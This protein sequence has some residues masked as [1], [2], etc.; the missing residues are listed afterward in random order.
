MYDSRLCRFLSVDPLAPKYPELTTY[1]FASNT[2]IMA[3][4]LDG[5]ESEVKTVA[6]SGT[7]SGQTYRETGSA[8]YF[9]APLN[10]SSRISIVSQETGNE[11]WHQDEAV[12]TAK[13]DAPPTLY[14]S[15]TLAGSLANF[16]ITFKEGVGFALGIYSYHRWEIFNQQEHDAFYKSAKNIAA[17]ELA[18]CK[19]SAVYGVGCLTGGTSA[20]VLKSPAL[21]SAIYNGVF[22]FGYQ[23]VTN[24]F[25]VKQVNFV[26]VLSSS[27]TLTKIP[28]LNGFIQAGIGEGFKATYDGGYDGIGGTRPVLTVFKDIMVGGLGNSIGDKLGE[29]TAQLKPIFGKTG[30]LEFTQTVSGNII[31]DLIK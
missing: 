31:S 19:Y 22:E 7:G 5:L 26:N 24:K 21:Q 13:R 1:Q 2:P 17:T 8:E 10:G 30:F 6:S 20:A 9:N 15:P 12:I 11:I 4:D 23:M 18:V 29:K 3:I 14:Q 25:D 28:I 16:A 27:L